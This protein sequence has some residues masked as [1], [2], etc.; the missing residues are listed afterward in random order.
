M[1]K[2]SKRS[3]SIRTQWY[4]MGLNKK[5]VILLKSQMHVCSPPATVLS[6]L[7]IAK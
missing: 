4:N 6:A 2:R 3:V 1:F 7:I 5:R